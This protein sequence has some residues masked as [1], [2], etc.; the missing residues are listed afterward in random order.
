VANDDRE[1]TPRTPEQRRADHASI[2]RLADELLPALVAKLGAS[3]LGELEIREGDW[4]VRLRMPGDGRS[5][6]GSTPGR[7]AG[8]VEG[9]VSGAGHASMAGHAGSAGAQHASVP[10]ASTPPVTAGT[11]ATGDPAAPG[12]PPQPP[13]RAVATSPAVGYFR[14]LKD[15]AAGARVRAGDRVGSVDVLGIPQEVVAPADGLVGASFVEAGDPV[16]YG[17]EIM[18]IELLGAPAAAHGEAG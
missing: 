4:H 18:E 5:R 12:D 17:Q 14:P 6:R 2:D 10:R 7:S 3:G 1:P 8:R 11:A 13:T 16:E 9:H 15:L